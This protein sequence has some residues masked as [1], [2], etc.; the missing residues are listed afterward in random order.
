M[1]H[2]RFC[3]GI[4]GVGHDNNGSELLTRVRRVACDRQAAALGSGLR[5]FGVSLRAEL[6]VALRTE[7][8]FRGPN[9]GRA[10]G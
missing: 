10:L 9:S 1:A 8:E 7:L 3:A 4:I 5:T 2:P 6:C